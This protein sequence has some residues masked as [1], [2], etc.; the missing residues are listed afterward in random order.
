ML[1]VKNSNHYGARRFAALLDECDGRSGIDIHM[2]AMDRHLMIGKMLKDHH[3]RVSIEFV[4]T[5]N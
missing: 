1:Q 3:P 5:S 4:T 2:L